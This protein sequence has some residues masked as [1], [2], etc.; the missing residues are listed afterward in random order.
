MILK[1]GLN[2]LSLHSGNVQSLITLKLSGVRLEEAKNS[3]PGWPDPQSASRPDYVTEL[4]TNR[5][6]EFPPPKAGHDFMVNREKTLLRFQPLI[7]Y[8]AV[9]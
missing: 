3:L 7:D 5:R 4:A 8:Y 1:G 9:L 6:C 2:Q